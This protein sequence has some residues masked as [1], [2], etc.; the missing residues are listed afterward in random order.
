MFP[1][2]LIDPLF[3]STYVLVSENIH[4]TFPSIF[5]PGFSIIDPS[6]TANQP[7]S[8][9]PF[10]SYESTAASIFQQTCVLANA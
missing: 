1:S 7:A 2:T 3:Q 4:L 6:A 5:L 8:Y 9:A 10:T